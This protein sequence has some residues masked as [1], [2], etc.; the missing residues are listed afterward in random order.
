[1]NK[2]FAVMSSVYQMGKKSSMSFAVSQLLSMHGFYRKKS[3]E[4][5]LS[6]LYRRFFRGKRKLNLENPQTLTEKVQW[7]KLYDHRSFYTDMVDKYE[8]KKIVAE[9][10][11]AE[12]VIPTLGVYDCFEDIDFEALPDQFVLKCTHDSGGIFFCR[13]KEKFNK[14]EARAF[15]E[16]RLSSEP[17]WQSREWAYKNIKPRIIAEPLIDELGKLDS[18]EYKVSCFDG[19]VGFITV[20][21]GIAHSS[22]DVR[23]NDFYD[24]D[25][26]FLPFRTLYYENSGIEN[27]K[28]DNLDEIV[29]F[30]EKIS[31]GIPYVRVD[32]YLLNGKIYF[33]ETTFYTWGGFIHFVPEEWDK[34]LGDL[35][36]LPAKRQ[37]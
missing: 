18:V 27:E 12:H 32:F 13:D 29:S 6:M 35:I 21:R 36:K 9:R 14:E 24:R 7:L 3:D 20:C 4:D 15:F 17:F 30:C 1:M 23:K 16:R 28:P 11:G 34:K 37:V 25:F 8:V 2:I 5:Y 33:G 26:N 22:F 31:E 19:K 10:V